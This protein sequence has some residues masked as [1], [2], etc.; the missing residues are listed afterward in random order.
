[1]DNTIIQQGRIVST[2]TRINLNLRSDVDWVKVRNFTEWTAANN[3]H[4]F[5]YYWQRGM[6]FNDGFI[7]YHPAAD[8]T[9]AVDTAVNAGV[10]GFIL[11]D[12]SAQ[13]AGPAVVY[14]D[15]SA[16]AQPVIAT[17]STAGLAAGAIVRLTGGVG[18]EQ[19]GGMDFTIDT[20][21]ANTSFRLPYMAQIVH[22][23]AP[24]ARATWR[25]IPY[26]PI[27]YPR[28]RFISAITRA[29]QMVVTMTVTHGYQIG[30]AVRLVV[31]AAYGMVEANGLLG[32]ITAVSLVN[33]TIT[34]DIDS[35][36]F[37]AFA[38]P[39]SGAV[40]FTFAE[41]VPVGENTGAAL[42]AIPPADILTDATLN[43][44]VLGISLGAG[45]LS[46]AGSNN[47]VL[48]WVAGK[49]FNV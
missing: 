14:T 34:L 43:T 1:M 20:I 42:V 49:S 3:G 4:G 39:V 7:T 37:T 36:L 30:Q 13:I 21:V 44:A 25:L 8:H 12:S 16:G 11:F 27:F 40:P 46:P 18:C 33:N 29:A 22:A 2:G 26:D 32:T 15:A 31:P 24:T 10:D 5:E 48:Y 9:A 35:T 47:D 45:V 19:L 41:V 38:F 6:A 17:G 28:R 23:G